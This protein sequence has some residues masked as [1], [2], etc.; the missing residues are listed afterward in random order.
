MIVMKVARKLLDKYFTIYYGLGDTFLEKLHGMTTL[1][2]Y[3]ADE[4]ALEE[5]DEE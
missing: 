5:M 3:Q 4:K 2:I 1:K